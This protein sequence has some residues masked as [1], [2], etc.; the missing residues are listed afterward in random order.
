MNDAVTFVDRER[1]PYHVDVVSIQSQVI[2]GR[3]GNNVAGPIHL[4]RA[5]FDITGGG[6]A[7]VEFL[8]SGIFDQSGS[9]TLNGNFLEDGFGLQEGTGVD[10]VGGIAQ[11][12]AAGSVAFTAVPEPTSLSLLGIFGAAI[13][14]MRRRRA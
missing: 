8:P 3:V 7:S 6:G 13:A 10:P 1:H 5:T 9:S 2:Y 4:M 12:F 14:G 11:T